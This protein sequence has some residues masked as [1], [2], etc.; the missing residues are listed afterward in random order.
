MFLYRAG[1]A[2][3]NLAFYSL[4]C[5]ALCAGSL[6]AQSERGTITGAVRDSSG[7][8]VPGAKITITNPTTNVNIAAISNDQ[9]EYTV[10][11]LSPGTYSVRVEKTCFPGPP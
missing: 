9:G 8:V 3:R 1:V 11:S 10:P 2:I 7:A 6:F 4:V 5:L